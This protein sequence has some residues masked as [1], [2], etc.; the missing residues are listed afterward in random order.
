MKRRLLDCFDLMFI[1]F[2]ILPP[3]DLAC[4]HLLSLFF[5]F[6]RLWSCPWNDDWY[7]TNNSNDAWFGNS[8]STNS[9]RYACSKGDHTLQKLHALP[10]QPKY[11]P[12]F[13]YCWL[14]VKLFSSDPYIELLEAIPSHDPSLINV[15][16]RVLIVLYNLSRKQ[17][18]LCLD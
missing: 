12:V 14:L 13:C 5:Y 7:T 15:L 8:T 11:K 17:L 2:N 4:Y 10:S 18:L 6:F 16:P 9:S 3:F 1:M